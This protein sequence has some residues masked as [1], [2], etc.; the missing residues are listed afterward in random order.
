MRHLLPNGEHPTYPV[1]VLV[2]RNAF[3]LT[4]INKHITNE[5]AE[6]AIVVFDLKENETGKV[7]VKLIKGYLSTLL[8]ALTSLGTRYIY[9][10]DS[11]YY[12]ALTGLKSVASAYGYVHP[13]VMEGFTDI[14]VVLGINP[15]A[16]YYDPSMKDKAQQGLDALNAHNVGQ[17]KDI[18][19]D[20]VH[21]AVY[22]STLDDIK[23]FL[24]SL[25]QYPVLTA[26]IEALSLKFW[27]AGISSTAFAWDEHNG[28][29]FLVDR[30]NKNRIRVLLKQFFVA[31]KG[32]LIW[33]NMSYDVKVII[34]TLWMNDLLDQEGMLKGLEVMTE[35]FSDT[36]IETFLATNSCAGNVL[37][38]KP[39]T[40]EYLGDY[41]EDTTDTSLI[42]D[43]DLLIYNLKDCLGTFWLHKKMY[44]KMIADD[45]EFI[46][47]NLMLPSVKL[48]LQVELTG[49]CMDMDKV[50]LAESKLKTI[51]DASL[52]VINSS[53]YTAAYLKDKQQKEHDE[54]NAA[55]KK[56]TEPLEYF[57]Y[58]EFNPN[59]GQ[60]VGVLLHDTIGLPVLE[61]TPTGIPCTGAD[62]LEDLTH[63][64]DDVEVQELLQAFV[65]LAKVSKIIT[66][67]IP[68][69]KDALL[70]GDGYHY[71]HGSFNVTGTLSARLSCSNPNL[72]TIPSGSKYA[73]IIK[74]CFISPTGWIFCGSDYNALESV[75]SAKITQDPNK[76][77]VFTDGFDSHCFNVYYYTPEKFLDI[78]PTVK[79][80]NSIKKL[81]KELRDESKPITFAA[82]YMGTYLTFM[83]S[84]G[85]SKAEAMRI[86]DNYHKLYVVSDEWVEEKL[87]QAETLGYV[88]GAFG[89]RVRTPVIKQSVMNVS[90]TTRQ[91]AAEKRSAGNALTQSY[92]VLNSRSAIEFMER[93]RESKYALDIRPVA[94]IHDALYLLIR[95]D[96]EVLHWV[97]I[98]LAECM[99]WN[100][101]PELQQDTIPLGGELDLFYPS[102]KDALTLPNGA[103][104]PEIIELADNFIEGNN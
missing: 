26:D 103:T 28:G 41:A 17:Y 23:D 75:I 25:H 98:N 15:K 30:A 37:G 16:F 44:P 4:I 78:E 92:C 10:A 81:H 65:D 38:L 91:A 63:H 2:R 33:H 85:L 95:N 5:I 77:K 51:E 102:W 24:D 32:K 27:E 12:K 88:T 74:E 3:N 79:G 87:K 96:L 42:S 93:V 64:T 31:Y 34:Y 67:F 101:L 80:I 29:A 14:Q 1:A 36:M 13:C 48:L 55:W 58:V 43:E 47:K 73:K 39:N 70:K 90:S 62:E 59:S 69:F 50:L 99:A 11:A 56:K 94:L 52:A 53:K 71:L 100:D 76:I 45:Q 72:Q 9:V 6:K 82:Q 97:N 8:P 104:I 86:E 18:G 60:Q 22:P 40:Q 68:A 35:N 66:S 61:T 46:Y 21:S 83:K 54:C 19:L 7:P 84:A 89:L 49:M 57:S 20:V